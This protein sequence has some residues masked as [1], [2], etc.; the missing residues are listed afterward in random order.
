[1]I[2]IETFPKD[3]EELKKNIEN[4]NIKP[5]NLRTD[6]LKSVIG[7][8]L[9]DKIMCSRIFMIGTGAI[10]CELLKNFAMISLGT[11]SSEGK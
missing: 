7:Q 6:G 5:D 3:L 9:L 1:M 11:G 8:E 2:P 4:I 10:G